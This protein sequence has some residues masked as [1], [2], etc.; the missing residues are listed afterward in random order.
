MRRRTFI[1]ALGCAAAAWPFAARAQPNGRIPVIGYLHPLAEAD[2][3]RLGEGAAF[4]EGL[5]DLGYVAGENL[6]IEARHADRQFDRLKP[7]AAQLVGLNVELIVTAGPGVL[8]ARS[9]TT[10]V[11]IVMVAPADVVATGLAESLSHPGANL[12]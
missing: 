10:T 2:D 4:G 9:V 6:R 12:T 11:P 1:A 3:R 7:L 5:R 8:A